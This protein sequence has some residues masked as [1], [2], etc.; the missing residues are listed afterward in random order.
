MPID[1]GARTAFP[2]SPEILRQLVKLT[3]SGQFHAFPISL[4][5]ALGTCKEVSRA[6]TS[7]AEP[8]SDET[9]PSVQTAIGPP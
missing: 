9:V 1:F 5:F 6:R 3:S 2:A 7:D 4:H 8:R